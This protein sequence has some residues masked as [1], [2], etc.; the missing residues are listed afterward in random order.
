MPY[1]YHL[2]S[3]ARCSTCLQ[4]G[5]SV[6]SL[7]ADLGVS[8]QMICNWRRQDQID[9]G[10]E[11]GSTSEEKAELWAALRRIGEGVDVPRASLA[12]LLRGRWL[13]SPT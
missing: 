2:S 9:R 12:Q 6:A 11:P 4:L 8:D 10:L 13:L 1:R 3:V 7:S 5:R